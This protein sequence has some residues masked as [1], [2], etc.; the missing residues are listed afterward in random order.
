MS[1][2]IPAPPLVV[3]LAKAPMPGMTMMEEAAGLRSAIA[4]FR[5]LTTMLPSGRCP[6]CGRRLLPYPATLRITSVGQ[7]EIGL[8]MVCLK[9]GL[10]GGG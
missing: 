2:C 4:P 10:R 5:A 9:C 7:S 6:L 1:R 8:N 3:A